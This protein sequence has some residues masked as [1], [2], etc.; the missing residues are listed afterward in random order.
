MPTHGTREE[1]KGIPAKPKGGFSNQ[2]GPGLLRWWHRQRS[3]GSQEVLLAEG[4]VL[5]SSIELVAEG[6][7][8]W[9]PGRV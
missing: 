1:P 8:R 7:G 4:E 3:A 6:Q 9:A 2:C 5:C